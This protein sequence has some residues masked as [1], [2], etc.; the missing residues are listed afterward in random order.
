MSLML[1][2]LVIGGRVDESFGTMLAG[3]IGAERCRQQSLGGK[4]LD[5][6]FRYC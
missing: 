3:R 2:R 4:F 6:Q 1:E 5:I